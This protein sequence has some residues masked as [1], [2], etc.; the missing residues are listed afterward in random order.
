MQCNEIQQRWGN[1]TNPLQSSFFSLYSHTDWGRVNPG[2]VFNLGNCLGV[3]AVWFTVSASL[4]DEKNVPTMAGVGVQLAVVTASFVTPLGPLL[5]PGV[6]LGT[7][8][9]SGLAS[10]RGT[11][12][13]GI[14]GD[15]KLL[16]VRG[17]ADPGSDAY[18]LHF[19]DAAEVAAAPYA[20]PPSK[21]QLLRM[22]EAIKSAGGG[23][24]GGSSS[25][26]SSDVPVKEEEPMMMA[27]SASSEASTSSS[28]DLR[29][30]L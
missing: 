27:S 9:L 10:V 4:Y 18:L 3:G 15:G 17:M 16:T 11:S 6:L 14:Y 25:S 30:R 12:L 5:G 24:G 8:I 26:M 29:M 22:N 28:E 21:E 2:D 7:T 23:G 1:E 19:A 13:S 20:G